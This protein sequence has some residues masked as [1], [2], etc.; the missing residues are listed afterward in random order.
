M[1]GSDESDDDLDT[2][3]AGQIIQE[4]LG[5]ATNDGDLEEEMPVRRQSRHSL[6]RVTPLTRMMS[7]K[8]IDDQD[9][10]GVDLSPRRQ[11][12]RT[13]LLRVGSS[14]LSLG[15]LTQFHEMTHPE[16]ET[17]TFI[18]QETYARSSNATTRRGAFVQM[19]TVLVVNDHQNVD[20]YA[21]TGIPPQ[22]ETSF[23]HLVALYIQR[24]AIDSLDAVVACA[25]TLRIL[26]VAANALEKLPPIEFWMAFTRLVALDISDNRLHKWTHIQSIKVCSPLILL[27][28]R[29]N[30]I[31]CLDSCRA[32]VVNQMPFLIVVDDYVVTD[33]ERI[34]NANFGPRY[35]AKHAKM[36]ANMWY[37]WKDGPAASSDVDLLPSL[38][39][40]ITQIHR[41]AEKNSPVIV[42]QR[43]FRG[44]HSRKRR[45]K[46]FPKLVH[47]ARLIQRVFRGSRLRLY[48]W[49][50]LR[51]L[52]VP[53][54][55]ITLLLPTWEKQR[56]RAAP[57]IIAMWKERRK[58][59]AQ[60]RAIN[61][62]KTWLKSVVAESKEFQL[63]LV[64][65]GQLRIY[66][67]SSSLGAIL[68]VA[69][70][71]GRRDCQ[72]L[73]HDVSEVSKRVFPTGVSV[74]RPST[75]NFHHVHRHAQF[76]TK[77]DGIFRSL[78]SQ[79]D[80]Q[81]QALRAEYQ[82]VKAD[83][84][85]LSASLA[86]RSENSHLRSIHLEMKQRAAWL[87][88]NWR[89]YEQRLM[90]SSNRRRAGCIFD[91]QLPIK[92]RT[93]RQTVAV[94]GKPLPPWKD[95][96]KLYVFVPTSVAMYRRMLYHLRHTHRYDSLLVYTPQD[97]AQVC[98]A[99][100]IQSAYRSYKSRYRSQFA[101]LLIRRRAVVCLQRWWR[102][103]TSVPRRLDMFTACL[104]LVAAIDSRILY[105]EERVL[106]TLKHQSLV[107]R[108]LATM[109]RM[110][111]HDWKFKFTNHHVRLP[112]T[113]EESLSRLRE[114]EKQAY[115][116]TFMVE[117][118]LERVGFPLW[119]PS[120]PPHEIVGREEK[121]QCK[122]QVSLIF[123]T[124]CLE[125][126]VLEN[127]VEPSEEE[128]LNTSY[129]PHFSR[130]GMC[131]RIIQDNH[132][133]MNWQS[134]HTNDLVMDWYKAYGIPLVR[135]EFDTIKEARHRAALLLV[136]TY[137]AR[138]KNYA[139]LYT[140]GML[141]YLWLNKPG[142]TKQGHIFSQDWRR[143]RLDIP[144]KWGCNHDLYTH[145]DSEME[146]ILERE[147]SSH[148][149]FT[150]PGSSEV[151][152]PSDVTATS[153]LHSQL[154]SE[155]KG[156]HESAASPT[157]SLIVQHLPVQS[158]YN[159]SVELRSLRQQQADTTRH[160]SEVIESK[161]I[162]ARY[163]TM[164]AKQAL[165]ASQHIPKPPPMTPN[166]VIAKNRKEKFKDKLQAVEDAIHADE[167]GEARAESTLH[168]MRL[169]ERAHRA[170]MVEKTLKA[171]ENAAKIA[172]HKIKIDV[173]LQRAAYEQ[174]QLLLVKQQRKAVEAALSTRKKAQ[175]QFAK[176]FGQKAVGL[177]RCN[178]RDRDQDRTVAEFQ[179]PFEEIQFTKLKERHV[180][181][182]IRAKRA[183]TLIA[184]QKHRI[185]KTMEIQAALDLQE[186]QEYQRLE[187][188]QARIAQE[189][190]V[191]HLLHSAHPEI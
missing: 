153:S 127:I 100:T 84:A 75:F 34:K 128:K 125:S 107:Q 163:N 7:V 97:V 185:I 154:F 113:L 164:R 157:V 161:L 62:I 187:D 108:A 27:R 30:P 68:E 18:M 170:V 144:C 49:K 147:S 24:N 166:T 106:L 81:L 29:G 83:E 146:Q 172:S 174:T 32:V 36:E 9:G 31:A 95:P 98:A 188:I 33:E 86:L 90:L 20:Q 42:I 102:F 45:L 47:A 1:S 158:D 11:S 129:D 77:C 46:A 26:N 139:R 138:H 114:E 137:D 64:L 58:H 96:E 169:A 14:R 74:L 162:H 43:Y 82:L 63:Q 173:Q 109:P 56:Y 103:M 105:I 41:L 149:S 35:C 88:S 117:S 124:N 80:I 39:R 186:D 52:L 183:E 178:A 160:E 89:R 184:K 4:L 120:T 156:G 101:F 59:V 121:Q 2:K 48:L 72:S 76:I 6:T 165:V 93:K 51:D 148:R 19:S 134:V 94:A 60:K 171:R 92:R 91:R 79:R 104:R 12:A 136:K 73:G 167:L 118:V 177:M 135:L 168:R 23:A 16:V 150:V 176:H 152:L 126:V 159:I 40:T 189:H 8:R 13:S 130:F 85:S 191:R 37:P 111:S 141:R 110:Q 112:I 116:S 87:K 181:E 57:R 142:V 28:L 50:Q 175:R 132:A 179:R 133:L 122:D 5:D 61:K 53:I 67:N 44:Y 69:S 123:T 38:A 22:I 190:K 99:T 10:Q 65:S 145:Q 55:K 15:H 180:E 3:D 78:P 143:M 151:F 66:C 17:S 25:K 71:C 140:Y 182:S 115:L 70:I 119:I 131:R 54:N 21:Y 155:D